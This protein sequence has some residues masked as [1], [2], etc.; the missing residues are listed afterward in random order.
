MD[1][2]VINFVLGNSYHK[3][4]SKFAFLSVSIRET[5]QDRA[6]QTSRLTPK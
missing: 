3:E 6:Q 4:L 5:E 2:A 1:R